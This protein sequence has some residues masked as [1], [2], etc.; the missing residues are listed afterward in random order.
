MLRLS[1]ELLILVSAARNRPRK[2]VRN[3]AK[4][5][6]HFYLPKAL[7]SKNNTLVKV[8]AHVR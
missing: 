8:C 5:E 1:N 6:L 4:S 3:K 7:G 2:N